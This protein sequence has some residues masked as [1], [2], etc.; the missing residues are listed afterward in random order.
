M[1]RNRRY[2]F[3][4][5]AVVTCTIALRFDIRHNFGARRLRLCQSQETKSK[6]ENA[7]H[8]FFKIHHEII[9]FN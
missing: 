2:S 7:E 4:I 3:T 1:K 5:E 8:R 6:K 9:K